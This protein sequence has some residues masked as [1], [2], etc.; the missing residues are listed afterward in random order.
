MSE[1][2][3]TDTLFIIKDGKRRDMTVESLFDQHKYSSMLGV[4]YSTSGQFINK[5]LS[6][7]SSLTLVVGIPEEQVHADAAKAITRHIIKEVENIDDRMNLFVELSTENKQRVSAGDFKLMI[8][9]G[10]AI[11][12][13]FYILWNENH[14]HSRLILGSANLSS[15]AFGHGGTQFEDVLVFDDSPIANLMAQHFQEDLRPFL[16]DYVPKPLTDL[17]TKR[18]KQLPKEV[19]IDTAYIVTPQQLDDLKPK[20]IEDL[21]ED[22]KSKLTVGLLPDTV[23]VHMRDDVS[24][25]RDEHKTDDH[26]AQLATEVVH[27]MVQQKSLHPK[28]AS[29]PVVRQHVASK[30]KVKTVANITGG[31]TELTRMYSQPSARNV[32]NGSSGLLVEINKKTGQMQPMGRYATNEEIVKALGVLD[33]LILNY[34][35]YPFDYDDEY[36][37][38]VIEAILYAFTAPFLFELRAGFIAAAGSA[39]AGNDVPRFLF[40][41]GRAGSGKS[42]L[43]RIIAKMLGIYGGVPFLNYDKI[44]PDQ[45]TNKKSS[46]VRQLKSWLQSEEVEPLLIDELTSDFFETKAYGNDLVLS[47]SNDSGSGVTTQAPVLIGTTNADSYSF[48]PQARRRSYYLKN[49]HTFDEER[50]QESNPAL[51]DVM[52]KINDDLF[53]DFILRMS[54]KLQSDE[55][56]FD[57]YSDGGMVDFLFTTREIFKSYYS[58]AKRPLPPYFPTSRRDDS[59]ESNQQRW[60]KLYKA[61][62]ELFT[63]N[64]A[65]K[66]LMFAMNELDKNDTSRYSAKPS[67]AYRNA[68][69]PAITF[70]DTEGIIVELKAQEFFDWVKL[71]N[72]YRKWNLF[73]HMS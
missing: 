67:K 1:I 33:Q 21:A 70:G 29:A 5:Y 51:A 56:V 6:E 48:E 64:K 30:L 8:T 72:P 41:G 60:Q 73:G 2:G 52:G 50:R 10:Y 71:K 36:G 38:R 49:D 28:I 61:R 43:L 16:S 14:T 17:V 37:S 40:I 42:N 4:T 23:P 31:I 46:T 58:T 26:R 45:F 47:V 69:S 24:D 55:V 68:L 19:P 20:I 25:L 22:L 39:E 53:Q 65:S 44:L 35:T 59:S 13:K 66:T 18:V 63:Y 9:S 34:Q 27:E 3:K 12:E 15:Q 57:Q 32:L 7:L 54:D 11:H 62:P